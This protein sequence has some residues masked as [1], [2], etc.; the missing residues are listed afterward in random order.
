MGTSQA[1]SNTT[2][3]TEDNDTSHTTF[4]NGSNI[5]FLATHHTAVNTASSAHFDV[6]PSELPLSEDSYQ[7]VAALKDDEAMLRYVRRELHTLG[8]F[9]L[10][11][12]ELRGWVPY[13]SG[14]K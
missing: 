8:L 1:T 12:S 6:D 11:E 14:T 4:N 10:S 2:F 3:G 5:A 9:S 13:F 7:K